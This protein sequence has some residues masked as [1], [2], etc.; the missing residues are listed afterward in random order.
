MLFL[1]IRPTSLCLQSWVRL[2]HGLHSV[3]FFFNFASKTLFFFPFD[4]TETFSN[5]TERGRESGRS[6]RPR[7]GSF[8]NPTDTKE[9]RDRPSPPGPPGS[10]RRA[11][12]CRPRT[13]RPR[14]GVLRAGRARPPAARRGGPAPRPGSDPSPDPSPG[15]CPSPSPC[16]YPCPY[17]VPG[18][19]PT[20]VRRHLCP[21]R[22]NAAPRPPPLVH[23]AHWSPRPSVPEERAVIGGALRGDRGPA[24]A[25]GPYCGLDR[26]NA[27]SPDSFS[28]YSVLLSSRI[29]S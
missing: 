5:P 26:P 25:F 20:C 11:P 14:V 1:H 19:D 6:A 24:R 27:E 17:P 10:E 16:P 3:D 7:G 9:R 18:P 21:S 8:Q 23:A 22:V 12:A 13:A 2:C 29:N 15:P 4:N 28:I